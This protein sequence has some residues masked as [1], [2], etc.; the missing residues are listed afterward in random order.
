VGKDATSVGNFTKVLLDINTWLSLAGR[1]FLIPA[2][3]QNT[4]PLSAEY[5]LQKNQGLL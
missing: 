5:P 3:G 1:R 2:Y 4:L